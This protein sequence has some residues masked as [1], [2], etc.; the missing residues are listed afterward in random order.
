MGIFAS[1]PLGHASNILTQAPRNHCNKA[2]THPEATAPCIRGHCPGQAHESTDGTVQ[3]TKHIQSLP[4]DPG[5]PGM[6]TTCTF[7]GPDALSCHTSVACCLKPFTATACLE[8]TPLPARN[9]VCIPT[10]NIMRH[11]LV[12]LC[13]RGQMCPSRCK[14]C[15]NRV[16]IEEKTQNP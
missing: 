16:S 1:R 14:C 2:R 11:V 8:I 9:A 13:A 5:F 10:H 4:A 7:G 3:T 15:S 6:M 12:L